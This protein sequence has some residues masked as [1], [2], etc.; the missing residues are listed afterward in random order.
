MGQ[1]GTFEFPHVILALSY[2]AFWLLS[3]VSTKPKVLFLKLDFSTME[4]RE[5]MPTLLG[6]VPWAQKCNGFH[7]LPNGHVDFEQA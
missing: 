7:D 3:S 1:R 5:Y 2:W 6:E 4:C